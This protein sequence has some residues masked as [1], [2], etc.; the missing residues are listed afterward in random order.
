MIALKSILVPTDLTE[1]SQRAIEDARALAAQFG[2][3]LHI[4][5]VVTEP[6]Q[7]LWAGY[8]PPGAFAEDIDQLEASAAARVEASLSPDEYASGRVIVAA[9]WGDP[10]DEILRYARE[11]DIDLIVCGT[12]ARRGVSHVVNGSVAERVARLAPCPVLT[13]HAA[14]GKA[15]HAAA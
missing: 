7:I 12:H 8:T 5:H 1:C 11:H 2:G 14:D 10:S 3:S 13:V 15:L 9:A 4:L 6:V